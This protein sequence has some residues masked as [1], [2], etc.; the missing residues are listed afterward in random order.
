MPTYKFDEISVKRKKKFVDADGNKR[1]KTKKFF[2]TL[3]P[4]NKTVHGLPKTVAQI[5]DEITR[6]A[7]AWMA[8]D[9]ID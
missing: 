4:F 1:Q 5:Q 8:S 3:S 6:E 2:Q 9:A 7:D